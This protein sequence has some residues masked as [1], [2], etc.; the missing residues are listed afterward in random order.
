MFKSKIKSVIIFRIVFFVRV[1]KK[2]EILNLK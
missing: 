1:D 2:F